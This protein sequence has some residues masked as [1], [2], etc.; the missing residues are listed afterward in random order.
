MQRKALSVGTASLHGCCMAVMGKSNS[1]RRSAD[2][3]VSHDKI[4]LHSNQ[5]HPHQQ[6]EED[7]NKMA[8][9]TCESFHH[10][11][12]NDIVAGE[13]REAR[14]LLWVLFQVRWMHKQ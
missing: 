5:K 2:H 4:G 1:D 11:W 10:Q 12:K 3:H 14:E 6:N 8:T 9:A 7:M 13:I